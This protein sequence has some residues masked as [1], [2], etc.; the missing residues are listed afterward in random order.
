[1]EPKKKVL[2]AKDLDQMSDQELRDL[3]AANRKAKI[4]LEGHNVQDPH[5]QNSGAMKKNRKTIAR[6]LTI[7]TRRGVS[8]V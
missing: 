5:P 7:L 4:I 1:M 8:C 6:C 3:L 2:K